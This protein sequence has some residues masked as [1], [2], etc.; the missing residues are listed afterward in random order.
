MGAG[1]DKPLKINV[2][3]GGPGGLYFSLLMKL[4][5]PRHDIT[6]YE[7]NRSDDTFGFGVVFSDETLENFMGQDAK[8]YQEIRNAF[9]YWDTIEVRYRGERVRSGGHG[10]AGMWRMKLLNILQNR[11]AEE[12]VKISYETEIDDIEA[13]RDADLVLGSD[14]VNSLV[15]ETYKDTFK[16]TIDY[17]KTKF[18][19]LGTTQRFDA[20]TFIFKNNEHGWF[21]NHAYQY[22]QGQG[23]ASSTWILE[24]HE[25]TWKNAGF[26]Q[27][28]EEDTLAY[29]EDFFA[30]E[31]DGHKL[32]SNKSIW[33][34]FPVVSNESWHHENVVLIGDA[35]HTAQFSIGSGT[36]IAMEG[37]IALA[38]SLK[39]EKS[40]PAALDSYQDK[41]FM[42]IARL[43]RTAMVSLQWYENARRFNG[44]TAPQ[45]AFNFLSRS[46]SVTYENLAL[47][48][49]DY[50][51]AVDH[52]FADIVR[53]QEGVDIPKENPPKPMFLPFHIGNMMVQNRVVV[54]PM[55]QYSA[56][57]GTPTDWHMVHLGGFGVGGA[58]LVFTEMTNV[59]ADGRISPGC[60]GMYKDEHAP[61]WKK[62]V[63]F[64][65]ANSNAKIGMQLAHAGRKGSTKP[66]W[67]GADLP[68]DEGRWQLISA[69]AIPYKPDGQV[70]KE[71]DRA[72]MDTVRDNFAAAA[73]R[74]DEA[75]FDIIEVHM[76][77]GYLLSSFITPLSNVRTDEYGGSLEN[78][79][80]FPLEVL[81]A[82]RAAWPA[83]KPISVRISASDWVEGAGIDG[84]DAVEIAKMLKAH[85][86]DIID[87]SAGQTTPD[88]KPI[89]G[90]M[91]QTVFSEQ[92]RLEADVPTI[93]VGN[94]T[95]PDQVNTILASGRADMVALARLH[96]TDPHFT[97]RA[98]AHY[99]YEMQTWPKQYLRGKAQ[100]ESLAAA[101]NERL[102]ELL[103][104]NKP[105]SHSDAIKKEAA[106]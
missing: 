92:V 69:S 47:R 91:F 68:L 67:E 97:L 89:Y 34:N 86:A 18:V 71:M 12:G 19:W 40:V 59:S 75:G 10:F 38:Q 70:P 29:F 63:D 103:I 87:V 24:T 58:G 13:Y 43:Q 65:H 99:G 53:E 78:R 94:I 84:D 6:V 74:A 77:H 37:A 9:A 20:F 8:T 66:G 102:Q 80:R 64:V 46:K 82:V 44:M 32:L 100:A 48:D 2:I 88:A 95:T 33:R 104:A 51:K 101:E 93:T 57:D 79:M 15:R 17:R 16:P 11:C 73:Q 3:G 25:D 52:W 36:K 90:R 85:G 49:P 31:L 4:A 26:D 105:Q 42:E 41:R 7:R 1:M 106:E 30:E 54:S 27:A 55:C 22:G 5:D 76:A 21:Y 83:D 96:L 98:A 35:C 60:A 28:T 23:Q 62:I 72:D 56:E 50:G 14:G 39:E 81:D 61:A 45:Y